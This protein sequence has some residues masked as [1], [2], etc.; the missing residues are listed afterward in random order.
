[1][2]QTYVEF[3]D[4]KI[5]DWTCDIV[6][7]KQPPSLDDILAIIDLGQDNGPVMEWAVGQKICTKAEWAER[8]KKQTLVAKYGFVPTLARH[9]V[10][11]AVGS[12]KLRVTYGGQMLSDRPV[13]HPDDAGRSLTEEEARDRLAALVSLPDRQGP[14]VQPRTPEAG[15]ETPP[16]RG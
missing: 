6:R 13:Q 7:R 4:E 1:M 15:P 8:I 16:G 9:L 14:G 11:H 2:S 5:Q 10:D 12:W 3:L